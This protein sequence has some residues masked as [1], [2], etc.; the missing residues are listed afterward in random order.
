MADGNTIK[1]HCPIWVR[2]S[3]PDKVFHG[4]IA[5]DSLKRIQVYDH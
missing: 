1:M 2:S 3:E 4:G 5:I